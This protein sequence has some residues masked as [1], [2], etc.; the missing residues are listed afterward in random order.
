M[1]MRR[2]D[3]T[4][5][6]NIIS[7]VSKKVKTSTS[8]IINSLTFNDFIIFLL[9]YVKQKDIFGNLLGEIRVPIPLFY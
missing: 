4:S 1:V 6:F 2:V 8:K 5:Y 7:R 9:K 3:L